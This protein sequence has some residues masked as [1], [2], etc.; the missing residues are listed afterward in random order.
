MKKLLSL[1][2]PT[3]DEQQKQFTRLQAFRP[4]PGCDEGSFKEGVSAATLLPRSECVIK[5]IKQNKHAKFEDVANMYKQLVQINAGAAGSAFELLVH[6]FWQ[7]TIRE[8]G[9]KKD[10]E[11][12]LVNPRD[13]EDHLLRSFVVDCSTL[14]QDPGSIESWDEKEG[15][16]PDGYYTPENPR[17]PVL[18]SILRFKV[19]GKQQRLGVQVSIGE[20]H[21]YVEHR[22][23]LLDNVTEAV[24]RSL[25]LWDFPSGGKICT[26]TPAPNSDC[27]HWELSH[28]RCLTFEHRLKQAGL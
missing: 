14:Q 2:L 26:W 24:K 19:D 10:V 9:A 8:N 6:L 5:Y 23:K 20:R 25:V 11:L 12:Q 22:H 4:R 13:G 27:P 28:V 18:D 15:A 1:D 16:P 3:S 7:E 17:Y 21:G